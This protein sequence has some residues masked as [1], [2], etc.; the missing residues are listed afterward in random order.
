M[1]WIHLAY[2]SIY[3]SSTI[4]SFTI[5]R[6]VYFHLHRYLHQ[7]ANGDIDLATNAPP[8]G[9]SGRN[10][11][12]SPTHHFYLLMR[13]LEM[14]VASHHLS[15]QDAPNQVISPTRHFY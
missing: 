10:Q 14:F 3:S 1:P 6:I 12:T 4:V 15:S 2:S 5:S 9:Q 8:P 13:R 7:T 11:V